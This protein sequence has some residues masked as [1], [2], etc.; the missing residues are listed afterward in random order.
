[1]I[2]GIGVDLCSV[3]RMERAVRSAHFVQRVFHPEEVAYALSKGRPA[4]HFAGSFAAREAF[5]KATSLSMY[6]V[7]FRKVWVRRGESAPAIV[8]DDSVRA[9]LPDGIVAH[10]SISH[11]GDYAVAMVVIEDKP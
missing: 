1:M 6:S 9:L 3:A 8:F 4:R 2:V 5:S 11:D 7:A 10:L